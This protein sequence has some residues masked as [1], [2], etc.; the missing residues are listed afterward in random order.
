MIGDRLF[1]SQCGAG[2][3]LTVPPDGE[4]CALGP[5]LLLLLEVADAAPVLL[6]VGNALGC[7]RANLDQR[8]FHF[9]DHQPNDL[10]RILGFLQDCIDIGI[11]NIAES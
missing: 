9:L 3:V 7:C 8:V 11:N 1:L 2:K 10:F 6:A 5:F 4:F